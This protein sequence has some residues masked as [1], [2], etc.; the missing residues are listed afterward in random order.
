MNW[1]HPPYGLINKVLDLICDQGVEG[2]LIMP[3]WRGASWFPRLFRG[4]GRASQSVVEMQ[5]APFVRDVQK[6]GVS[7]KLL[8]YRPER[9]DEFEAKHTPRGELLA[10]LFG[11]E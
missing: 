6:L 2:V 7:N 4:S 8:K 5:R 3:E 10:I 11:F 1:V 9:S